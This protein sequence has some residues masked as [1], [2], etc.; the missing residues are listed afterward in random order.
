MS[1]L[2]YYGLCPPQDPIYGTSHTNIVKK[3]TRNNWRCKAIVRSSS[4][5]WIVK[6]YYRERN[7]KV[8]QILHSGNRR[9][10][11]QATE[12]CTKIC[13]GLVSMMIRVDEELNVL[14]F[15]STTALK[16]PDVKLDDCYNLANRLN[17][18]FE[19]LKIIIYPED[20]YL[21]CSVAWLN[22]DK[23]DIK[24][25]DEYIGLSSE[26]LSHVLPAFITLIRSKLTIDDALDILDME[27][28]EA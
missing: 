27:V 18:R 3:L 21:G 1:K 9:T 20:M 8:V 14:Y 28:G 4:Y 17:Q 7:R 5:I 19:I 26:G 2:T 22:I 13:T 11:I 10:R 15:D 23:L 25:L 6:G 24:E 16:I 12:R